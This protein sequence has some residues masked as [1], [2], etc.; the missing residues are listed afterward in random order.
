MEHLHLHSYLIRATT[1][2]G[3]GQL[4]GKVVLLSPS[5]YPWNLILE[6]VIAY[7][8]LFQKASPDEWFDP[9]PTLM[10]YHLT[11]VQQKAPTAPGAPPTHSGSRNNNG[12]K[13][14]FNNQK[15][16]GIADE[17][18]VMYNRTSG[19]VWKDKNGG[20]CPR[21]HVCIVCTSPQHT[22]S[23]CPG[24]SAK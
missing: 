13:A 20:K 18:C 5:Q 12:Q 14:K 10:A 1:C 17:I 22:A 8:R 4:D 24:K 7:Y 3:F 2:S 11:L 15:S 19:C 6:Y 21:R 23:T 16:E 9:N